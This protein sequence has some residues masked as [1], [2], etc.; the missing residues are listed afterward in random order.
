MQILFC[1]VNFSIVFGPNFGGGGKLPQGALPRPPV[2]ESQS[3]QLNDK[4]TQ[5]SG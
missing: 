5:S 2:K 3:L 1:Y 4:K